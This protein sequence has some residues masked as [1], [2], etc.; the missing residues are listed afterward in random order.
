[1]KIAALSGIK[2]ILLPLMVIVIG[3]YLI[4][5]RRT[6]ILS[7]TIAIAVATL[8]ICAHIFLKGT[9]RFSYFSASEDSILLGII[10]L[11]FWWNHAN[12]PF[13]I[14]LTFFWLVSVRRTL[15]QFS[16]IR[17]REAEISEEQLQRS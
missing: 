16:S 12:G 17:R 4:E 1:M 14:I 15:K 13:A 8:F 7:G 9:K 10:T 6:N 3:V 11:D 5:A 2:P